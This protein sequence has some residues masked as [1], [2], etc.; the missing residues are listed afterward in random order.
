MTELG[1]ECPCFSAEMAA[2]EASQYGFHSNA[3]SK[4]SFFGLVGVPTLHV[5]INNH[6]W[7]IVIALNCHKNYL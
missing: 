4:E 2:V 1:G 3:A 6:E 5:F 7:I